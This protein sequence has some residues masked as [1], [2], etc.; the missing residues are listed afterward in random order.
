MIEKSHHFP[1][2]SKKN[3]LQLSIFPIF[4]CQLKNI[5]YICIIISDDKNQNIIS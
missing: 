3:T 4:Y 2:F 1:Y 5:V